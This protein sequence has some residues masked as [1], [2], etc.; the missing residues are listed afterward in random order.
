MQIYG[1]ATEMSWW[2]RNFRSPSYFAINEIY[3]S[4]VQSLYHIR[5]SYVQLKLSTVDFWPR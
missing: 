1:N 5:A 3:Y 2:A 4:Y